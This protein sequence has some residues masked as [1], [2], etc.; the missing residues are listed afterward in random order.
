MRSD[1]LHDPV[2]RRR[3]DQFLTE[4]ATE[5]EGAMADGS[6]KAQRWPMGQRFWKREGV[7][8]VFF[9]LLSGWASLAVSG[10]P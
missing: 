7:G 1:G 5:E 10:A 3:V 8:G 6:G 9:F 2:L 4:G